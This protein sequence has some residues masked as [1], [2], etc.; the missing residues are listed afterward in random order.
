MS[1]IE[2]R[3]L[4]RASVMLEMEFETKQKPPVKGV[5]ISNNLSSGGAS[6]IGPQKLDNGTRLKLKISLGEKKRVVTAIAE[7]IWQKQCHYV[8]R[9]KQTYY[10]VGLR[11][12]DM[13]P[14]DAVL[15]S[16]FISDVIK[17]SNEM[18]EREIIDRLEK[19]GEKRK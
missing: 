19:P 18:V 11:F 13:K 3:R 6:V 4:F 5:F 8:P 16:D 10:A 12:L 15:T 17:E 7:I 9:S 2:Y 1:T 14:Q